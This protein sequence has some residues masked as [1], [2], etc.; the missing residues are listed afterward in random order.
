[1][2]KRFKRPM[3]P[4]FAGIAC[5]Y[6][7]AALV[8]KKLMQRKPLPIHIA[9][10]NAAV[11]PKSVR[12]ELELIE[13]AA[14]DAITRS[15]GTWRDVQKLA[16]A[17][18]IASTLA[19]EWKVGDAEC[20]YALRNGEVA[21]I[22]CAERMERT[23]RVGFSGTELQDIREML[24]WAHAQR[25]AVNRKTFLAAIKLT[26]ARIR[27]NHD[28]IDLDQACAVINGRGA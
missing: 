4:S 9:A 7:K 10:R 27:G 16:D 8:L 1:M 11:S 17:C 5:Q 12:E 26:Q 6:R 20:I 15:H 25:D 22:H 3:R 19:K 2:V 28:T 23:G 14:L 18:N 21:I 13:L 24:S